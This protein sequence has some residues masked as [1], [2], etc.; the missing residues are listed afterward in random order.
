MHLYVTFQGRYKVP[1]FAG[2]TFQWGVRFLPSNNGA[3]PPD[4][5]GNLPSD[6]DIYPVSTIHNRDETNW[7]IQGNWNLE[8]GLND[9]DPAD[10][11]NDQLGPATQTLMSTTLFSSN[12][13]LEKIRVYPIDNTG[14]TMPAVPYISGTPVTLTAKTNTVF[15]GGGSTSL[16][17][18]QLSAVCSWRTQQIGPGGRGRI[19]LAGLNSSTALGTDGLFGGGNIT[20][21]LGYIKT[22]LEACKIVG[23]GSTVWAIPSV[24]PTN[25]QTYAYITGARMGN[26][27]DTQRRRRR[28]LVET[29]SSTSVAPT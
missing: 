18:P 24:I 16:L 15:D 9:L 29:Y 13:Y 26:I 22:W 27:W 3:T 19:Y 6:S 25:W 10:W 5:I 8:A 20:T 12:A 21:F 2:E 17:P 28:S 23:S 14:K 4:S 1:Q 7:T 11:L